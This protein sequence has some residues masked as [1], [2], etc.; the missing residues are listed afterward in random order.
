LWALQLPLPPSPDF[1]WPD[2]EVPEGETEPL[3]VAPTPTA[4][5]EMWLRLTAPLIE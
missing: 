3:Y 4:P 5:K 1:Q 2:I